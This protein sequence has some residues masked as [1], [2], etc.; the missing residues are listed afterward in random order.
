[1]TGQSLHALTNTTSVNVSYHCKHFVQV[2]LSG[3]SSGGNMRSGYG[4][5]ES[6]TPNHREN[7]KVPVKDNRPLTDKGWQQEK[8]REIIDFCRT[9]NYPGTLALNNFPLSSS[10]FRKLFEFLMRFLIPEFTMPKMQDMGTELPGMLKKIG[11]PGIVSKSTFQTI[12]TQH[13]W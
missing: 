4:G 8:L 7:V 3:A 13:S 11:Y 5:R 12:G 1:M 9:E 2:P 10:E 6:M